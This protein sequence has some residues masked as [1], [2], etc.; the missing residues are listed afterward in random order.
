[1]FEWIEKNKEWLFSGAGAM[2]AAAIFN[3]VRSQIKA[4]KSALNAERTP[5]KNQIAT[6]NAIN[7]QSSGNGDISV[8]SV[9]MTDRRIPEK[10][11]KPDFSIKQ[12]GF[13][14]VWGEDP[15]YRLQISNS[16]GHCYSVE[17]RSH[18]F[19]P[20]FKIP[21]IHRGASK[22]FTVT[23]PRG[24]GSMMII[25]AGLD[26]NGAEFKQVLHGINYRDGYK[27]S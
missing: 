6:G 22:S 3:L 11:A 13:T 24:T 23:T 20:E 7:I 2:L 16:G 27:F 5:V 21:E 14:G 10:I 19:S 26:G 25:I 18:V 12:V 15:E 4:K 9:N 8:G 1:M 17:V